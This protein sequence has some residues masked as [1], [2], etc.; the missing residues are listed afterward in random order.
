MYDKISAANLSIAKV[1]ALKLTHRSIFLAYKKVIQTIN[2][3][4]T[5]RD[6]C[7]GVPATKVMW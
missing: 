3:V 4:N 7:N 6:L 5:V 2:K 1:F